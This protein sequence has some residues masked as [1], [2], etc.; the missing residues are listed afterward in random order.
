MFTALNTR[1]GEMETLL[2]RLS[3]SAVVAVHD[4]NTNHDKHGGPRTPFLKFAEEN[5]LQLIQFDTPRG[6]TLLRK[7]YQEPSHHQVGD[8]RTRE[9][10]YRA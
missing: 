4:T 7:A 5:G 6:L 3:P 8:N 10:A 9:P 2:E 1:I